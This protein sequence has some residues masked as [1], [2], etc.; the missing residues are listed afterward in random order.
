[1]WKGIDFDQI[2]WVEKMGKDLQK[3]IE[4]KSRRY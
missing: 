3:E 4:L 2:S 1:M